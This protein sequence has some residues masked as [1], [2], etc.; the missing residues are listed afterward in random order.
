MSDG[1]VFVATPPDPS[2][3]GIDDLVAKVAAQIDQPT[4]FIA[5]SMGSVIAMRVALERPDFVTHLVLAVT[6]G[7][8]DVMTLGGQDWRPSFQAANPLLPRWLSTHQE[9]F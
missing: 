5:Q 6:S 9:D 3:R 1:Q 7:G 2:V 4:A 8:I